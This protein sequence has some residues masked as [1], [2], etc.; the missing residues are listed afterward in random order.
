MKTVFSPEQ[1]LHTPTHELSDGTLKPAVEL[2]SRAEYV[3]DR[4]TEVGLGQ[5]LAPTPFGRAPLERVH[6]AHYIDFMEGFRALYEA[7]GRS[8]EAFPFCWPTAGLRSDVTPRHVD[9]LL[10]RYSFDAGT[11][12][13]PRSWQAARISTDTALTAAKMVHDGDNVAFALCRPPG[14]HAM[15]D[16]FGGYC[17]LNNAAIAAQWLRDQGAARVAVL[18]VDYHHGNGTQEIFYDRS[19]VLFLSIH[20]DPAVEYP[21]FLGYADE[22]GVG[23]GEGFTGNWPLPFGTDWAGWSAALEAACARIADYAPDVLVVSL[24]L[25]PF[26]NDPI[27][28]FKLTS[29][30]FTRLGAR[31]AKLGLRTLF[32]ME[33]GYAIDAL[34]VNCVNVLTGFEGA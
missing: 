34:G 27:S 26:E 33:G 28:N 17:F 10:G 13:G 9:G 31:L 7:E 11:P 32:V 1:L 14:H 18:D 25:D 4:I 5:I 19:D 30:D 3:R 29:D 8:G 6:T 21:Y 12:I 24:G 2:P 22:T 16:R 20:A 23:A 15:S